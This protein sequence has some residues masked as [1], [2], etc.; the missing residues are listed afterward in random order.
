MAIDTF[1]K[2]IE[3]MPVAS[4]KAEK[5]MDFITEIM[6]RFRVPNTIFTD[7][8]TQFTAAEFL[9]FCDD[10]GI[11][12]NFAS[13]AHPQSNGQVEHANSL[14][15]QG[16]KPRLF[17]RLKSYATRWVKELSSVL[18]A[19]RTT[20]SRATGQSPFTLDYGSEVMLPTEVDHKSFRVQHYNENQS[21]ES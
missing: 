12:V 6:H 5:A 16:L 2:W 3:A 15:L 1:T 13:V 20:P 14:I 11:K 8:G 9:D 18:W 10:K 7:N 19:L 17:N 4:I 21:D